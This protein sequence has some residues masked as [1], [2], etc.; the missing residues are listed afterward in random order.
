M[1]LM[2]WGERPSRV[3][4][5]QKENSREQIIVISEDLRLGSGQARVR[6]TKTDFS[7][8]PNCTR[9]ET[10]FDRRPLR[11]C[12]QLGENGFEPLSREQQKRIETGGEILEL[13]MINKVV[14][15]N[16][17]AVIAKD[18]RIFYNFEQ[19]ME[20]LDLWLR[21]LKVRFTPP[22]GVFKAF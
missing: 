19:G 13:P 7:L 20:K 1:L 10:F 17:F 8:L 14:P 11:L 9:I 12:G 5:E 6:L 2:N 16:V 18:G 22:L 21:A 3:N 4:S 15:E